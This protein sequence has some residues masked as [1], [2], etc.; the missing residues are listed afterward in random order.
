MTVSRGSLI[1]RWAYMWESDTVPRQTSLCAMF[2][3]SVLL[4][5]MKL[6]CVAVFTL[7]S[8]LA[9]V[10][11]AG[12]TAFAYGETPVVAVFALLI[13]GALLWRPLIAPALEAADDAWGSGRFDGLREAADVVGQ[14]AKAIKSNI[15]PIVTID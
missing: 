3:R 8:V 1:V 13:V 7:F 2:W 10:Y 5:P 9:L 6:F 15:C 11:L 14:G 12:F 4:T